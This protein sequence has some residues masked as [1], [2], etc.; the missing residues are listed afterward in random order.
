MTDYG[1]NS[2]LSHKWMSF[3]ASWGVGDQLL[4]AVGTG[5]VH[6]IF[7]WG[8]NGFLFVC[9][10]N[11]WLRSNRISYFRHCGYVVTDND[12]QQVI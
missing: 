7:F 11:N 4:F 12:I 6:M 9:Y 2:D 5:L 1:T 10:K 3:V 8:L